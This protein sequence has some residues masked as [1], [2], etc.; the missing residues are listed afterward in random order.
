MVTSS[1]QTALMSTS[2]SPSLTQFTQSVIASKYVHQP[3]L[4][5][6]LPPPTSVQPQL[7]PPQ[8]QPKK[9]YVQQQTPPLPPPS[10]VQPSQ[11]PPQT[12]PKK[13]HVKPQIPP[14]PPPSF[15]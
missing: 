11:P 10:S 8:P 4:V 3:P 13:K 5:A 14:L 2:A 9:K 7:L 1:S 12:Q 6:P 15:V